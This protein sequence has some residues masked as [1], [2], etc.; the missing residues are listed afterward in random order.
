MF[1]LKSQLSITKNITIHKLRSRKCFRKLL[2]WLFLNELVLFYL[3]LTHHPI[4]YWDLVCRAVGCKRSGDPLL[5]MSNRAASLFL[6]AKTLWMWVRWRS[7]D[8]KLVSS[9]CERLTCCNLRIHGRKLWVKFS[10]RDKQLN[11]FNMKIRFKTEALPFCI[12]LVSIYWCK[13]LWRRNTNGGI[14]KHVYHQNPFYRV[15]L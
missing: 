1:L 14:F 8:G 2:Q 15:T 5:G 7:P 13:G 3:W 12:L 6:A 4:F 10:R 9:L 11:D